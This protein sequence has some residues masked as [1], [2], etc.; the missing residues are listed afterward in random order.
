MLNTPVAKVVNIENAFVFSTLLTSPRWYSAE[1][2]PTAEYSINPHLDLLI[3][4]TFSYT[5]QTEDYN[6]FEIRP[7]VG[8]KI[9]LTPHRR[10][11]LRV[12]FRVEHRSIVNLDTD[13]WQSTLRPRTRAEA[14]VPINKKS[15]S[16][17]KLWYALADA[18][19]FFTIDDVDE[20]FANRFRVR[21]GVGYRLNYSSRFEFIYMNQQSK[22][23]V[24]N[25]FESSDNI[26][27]F[28]YK[29][30]LRKHRP[31]NSSGTGN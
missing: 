9:H 30:F 26:Y 15:F 10:V 12:L 21:V 14:I 4:A 24:D 2:T 16:E 20:R 11:L 22:N 7:T 29:H 18:E 19:W 23:G 5:L 1:Y 25:A 8:A 6:T 27:R 28:R 31:T 13:E 17:D 3:G